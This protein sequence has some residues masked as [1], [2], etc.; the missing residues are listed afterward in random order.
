MSKCSIPHFHGHRDRLKKRFLD[1]GSEHLEDYELLELILFF[2]LPRIDTKPIAKAL[3]K[4]FKTLNDV[5]AADPKLLQE[6]SGIGSNAALFIKTYKSVSERLVRHDI[7]K[8]PIL[9]TFEKVVDY[10][11]IHMAYNVNEQL[12]L[13]FLN[14][15][16]IL[17]HDEVQQY[18]TI[19]HTA[20]YPREVVKRA[21]DLGAASII[22][23]H[24]HPSGDPTPSN[25]DI[26]LTRQV[27]RAAESLGIS[28]HDHLIIGKGKFT[29]LRSGGYV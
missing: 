19:N 24:N 28:L 6:I 26:Q 23:I 14:T 12:R 13:L 2:C 20:M 4:R 18:G 5:F 3:L 16:N 15:K 17:I 7:M 9:D 1:K 10:C 29:S 21:L 11:Q 8:K 22:M 27:T 25:E